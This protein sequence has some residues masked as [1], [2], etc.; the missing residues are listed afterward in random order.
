MGYIPEIWRHSSGIFLPK[1]G[2]DD[3]YNPKS[4]RTITLA[5]VPLKW[6]ER[7]ILWHMETD[8]K[9]YSKLSKKQYGFKRGCSTI[10][11][12]HKLVRKL[13]IALLNKGMALGTFLDIEGAFDNVSFVAIERALSSN[14]SSNGVNQWIMSMIHNRKTTVELQGKKRVISIR[15]GCPQ[16]GIL[17][18]FL[19]NLVINELLEYTRDRIP[20]D[21]QGFEDDLALVSIVTAPKKQACYQGFDFDTL[22]EV[23]QKSLN[24]INQWCKHSGLKLSQLNTHCVM[25]GGTGLSVNP[26]R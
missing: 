4:Y 17:S 22:R 3:Y 10:A 8:L 19:W 9:I 23:T 1:P 5:P 11:A 12:T 26:S 18:P 7:V 15:K 25:Q 14:C 24:S 2:K 16:G 20:S 21:L 6:M 13:E